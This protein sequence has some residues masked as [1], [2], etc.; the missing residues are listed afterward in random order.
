[1]HPI[2]SNKMTFKTC[3]SVDY[4]LKKQILLSLISVYQ[5]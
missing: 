1:M 4:C 5:V 3:F 2:K